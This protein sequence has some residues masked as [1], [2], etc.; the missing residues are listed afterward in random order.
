LGRHDVISKKVSQGGY[1][2]R[3][4]GLQEL[5]AESGTAADFKDIVMGPD[6]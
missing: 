1:G 6:L 5:V 4:G 2:M 3:R